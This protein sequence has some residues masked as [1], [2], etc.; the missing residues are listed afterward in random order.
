MMTSPPLRARFM[1]PG[2]LLLFALATILATLAL[3]SP[4]LAQTPTPL[5]TQPPAVQQIDA[6]LEGLYPGEALTPQPAA[7]VDI[8]TATLAPDQP[9]TSATTTTAGRLIVRRPPSPRLNP[10]LAEPAELTTHSSGTALTSPTLPLTSP[11]SDHPG[12]SLSIFDTPTTATHAPATHVSVGAIDLRALAQA[13]P[14]TETVPS[15]VISASPTLATET[16][17]TTPAAMLTQV[18]LPRAPLR[19]NSADEAA[20]MHG[21]KLDARRARLIIEFRDTYGPYRRPDDLAGVNGIGDDMVRRWEDA[22]L[23]RFD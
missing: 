14:L 10:S 15:D 2:T 21:L 4:V 16:S 17:S 13:T 5:P 9:T 7:Q 23:L 20:L 19:I 18:N 6:L 22:G 12:I 1:I 3:D 11:G 8:S